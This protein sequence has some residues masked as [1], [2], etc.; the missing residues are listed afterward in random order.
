MLLDFAQKEFI[1]EKKLEGLTENSLKAYKELFHVFNKYF[2]DVRE[3]DD[4]EPRMIREFIVWCIEER[5]N[6]PSTVNTKIKL[7]RVFCKWLFE[8][9][10]TEENLARKLKYQR[11]HD[12][13]KILDDKELDIV[14]KQIRREKRRKEN[15]FQAR[16]NYALM[17][18]LAGS[19]LRISEALSLNWSHIDMKNQLIQIYDS[20]NGD[21]QSVPL[22]ERLRQELTD[23]KGYQNEYFYTK[24]EAVFVTSRGSRLSRAGAQNIFKRI[25]KKLGLKSDFSPHTLRNFYIKNLLKKGANLRE[26]QLL[27]RHRKI[28]V[29]RK[30]VGYFS[31]ELLETLDEKDALKDL[32]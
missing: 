29:T 7:L 8:E 22:T 4:L 19:G 18:T 26:V 28:D 6:A 30:Y 9:G 3:V 16:R 21:L 24:R 23:W 27:A 5:K 20:K 2:F 25:R 32:T 31:H 12:K 15:E 17:L 10:I 13:P 14:L 1:H 11:E